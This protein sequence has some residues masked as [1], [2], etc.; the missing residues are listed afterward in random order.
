MKCVVVDISC[1]N[2]LCKD[3]PYKCKY[4][5]KKLFLDKIYGS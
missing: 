2:I 4:M 1:N 3:C 5:Y